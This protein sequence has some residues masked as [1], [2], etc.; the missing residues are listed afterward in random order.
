MY[1]RMSDWSG[2][3]MANQPIAA[4]KSLELGFP[5][6]EVFSQASSASGPRVLSW[7]FFAQS[8]IMEFSVQSFQLGVFS[9]GSSA[10]SSQ[11][12]VPS[13]EFL[14]RNGLQPKIIS[15]K[16]S[17]GNVQLAVHAKLFSAARWSHKV[18]I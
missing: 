10:S 1:V 7:E 12:G 9:P 6:P 14:F 2:G 15:K 13:K 11:P 16:F 17:A 18:V 5:Q 8:F 3:F 4:S